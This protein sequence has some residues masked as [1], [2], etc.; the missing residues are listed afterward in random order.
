MGIDVYCNGSIIAILNFKKVCKILNVNINTVDLKDV[1][2]LIKKDVLFNDYKFIYKCI[3]CNDKIEIRCGL[4]KCFCFYCDSCEVC[5]SNHYYDEV[6][7][8]IFKTN[9][10]CGGK[11]IDKCNICKSYS[12]DK[13]K[14]C[15]KCYYIENGERKE[16]KKKNKIPS[17]LHITIDSCD[18]G[19]YKQFV[20]SEK[21][22]IDL[23]VINKLNQKYDAE[24]LLKVSYDMS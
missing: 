8:K 7:D 1:I 19:G 15:H 6:S 3:T 5:T 17:L 11:M 24:I 20:G 22:Y 13:C 2:I 4:E 14:M 12:C 16:K 21:D 18:A 9:C 23:K 10:V